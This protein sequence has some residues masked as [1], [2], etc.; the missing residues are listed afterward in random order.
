MHSSPFILLRMCSNDLLQITVTLCKMEKNST[1]KFFEGFYQ[2]RSFLV[3]SGEL[4]NGIG[5]EG[6]FPE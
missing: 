2:D 4:L 6:T 3:F 1:K 5:F